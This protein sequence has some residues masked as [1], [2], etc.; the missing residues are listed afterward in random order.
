VISRKLESQII[1][2]SS[3][4]DDGQTSALDVLNSMANSENDNSFDR[5]DEDEEEEE[6]EKEEEE[7][8]PG[9]S[10]YLWQNESQ[11]VPHEYRK[12]RTCRQCHQIG[13]DCRNCPELR[14][15][16]RSKAS[17]KK[18]GRPR[19]H[20][21]AFTTETNPT[22]K[23]PIEDVVHVPQIRTLTIKVKEE[24]NGEN[25]HNENGRYSNNDDDNVNKRIRSCSFDETKEE[26]LDIENINAC[27]ICGKKVVTFCKNCNQALCFEVMTCQE[28]SLGQR[29]M[30]RGFRRN[31]QLNS[32]NHTE[33]KSCW[34]IFHGS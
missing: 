5:S 32:I 27:G 9:D 11:I 23:Y 30:G 19:K 6:Q 22:S 1:M 17:G 34:E 8:D 33:S 7:E 12:E 2:L 13:H 20:M 10:H 15:R 3:N 14:A 28:A 24:A 29:K 16:N 18:R 25:D 21:V 26:T 31:A 4:D